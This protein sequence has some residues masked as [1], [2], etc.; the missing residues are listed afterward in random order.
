[1]SKK[2]NLTKGMKITPRDYKII[3]NATNAP[4]AEVVDSVSDLLEAVQV[5]AKSLSDG[6]QVQDILA[7]LE[8]Q[9]KL[10]EVVVDFPVFLKELIKLNKETSL[11]AVME[12]RVRLKAQ[13][14]LH[15]W[16]NHALR[17]LFVVAKG[18]GFVVDSYQGGEAQYMLIQALVNGSPL[19]PDETVIA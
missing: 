12:S 14:P 19:F 17:F 13:G 9:P 2:N 10:N 8:A 5:L 6:F 16:T 18:Y 3:F 15:P 1:M 11:M 4:Y 7:V